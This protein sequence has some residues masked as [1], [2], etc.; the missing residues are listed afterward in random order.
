[1]IVPQKGSANTII[2]NA[3]NILK[4]LDTDKISNF[5]AEILAGDNEKDPEK[6]RTTIEIKY[7][8]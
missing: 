4:L 2:Q 3:I 7:L 5:E 1:M 8:H 6:V